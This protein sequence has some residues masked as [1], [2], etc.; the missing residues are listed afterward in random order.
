[1]PKFTKGHYSCPEA[2][3]LSNIR[4][5]TANLFIKLWGSSSNRYFANKEKMPIF[6]KAQIYKEPLLIK[7][8][9]E[10]IQKYTRSSTGHYQSIH[11]V[12][13]L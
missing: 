9:S 8:F 6:T 11:Q 7:C 4:L 10:I 13:R 2:I 5:I 1:M 3:G 12:P